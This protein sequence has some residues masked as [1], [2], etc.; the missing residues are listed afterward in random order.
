VDASDRAAGKM[1]IST[2]ISLAA[3]HD[4]IPATAMRELAASLLNII[5]YETIGDIV[6]IH[7]VHHAARRSAAP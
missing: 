3:I 6:K 5:R 7:H 2:E 4:P 1:K